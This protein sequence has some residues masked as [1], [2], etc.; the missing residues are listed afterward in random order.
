MLSGRSS[1]VALNGDAPSSR[2]VSARGGGF[3][4]RGRAVGRGEVG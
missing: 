3:R 1:K 4:H 2:L